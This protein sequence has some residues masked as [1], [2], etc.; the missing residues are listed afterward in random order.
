M[1]I[2]KNQINILLIFLLIPGYYTLINP[3]QIV[4]ITVLSYI[5][6]LFMCV[7]YLF[8]NNSYNDHVFN[9]FIFAGFIIV[10][11]GF[12]NAQTK[13]DYGSLLLE[14]VPVALIVPF[15]YIIGKNILLTRFVL[16]KIFK[17]SFAFLI[18]PLFVYVFI[19]KN[20]DTSI[21][22]RTISPFYFLIL[23]ILQVNPYNKFKIG[24]ISVISIIVALDHRSNIINILISFIIL[25]F[26]SYLPIIV[27]YF[28][29]KVWL[30][31]SF[32]PLIFLYL[33]F[34]NG[35]FDFTNDLITDS[36]SSIYN[37]VYSAIANEKAFVFGLGPK[38]VE[39]SLVN[40]TH[41]NTNDIYDSGRNASESLMLNYFHWGGVVMMLLFSYFVLKGVYLSLF[42]SRNKI[43]LMIALLVLFR[44]L[45][46]FVE[47]RLGYD[48]SSFFYFLL[49]GLA[50]NQ[51]LRNM[52][53]FQVN[54]LF[55]I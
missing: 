33:N 51:Q 2:T 7:K 14:I 47:Y 27:K 45:Y 40:S 18:I 17:Y 46:S 34:Y 23:I 12:I 13:S 49:I 39:T 37:D 54:K 30:L 53:D 4:I 43:S 9:A 19:N 6:V 35:S 55:K 52:N 5:L 11:R 24:I 25:I 3:G 42:K 26:V 20:L 38:K 31:L 22:I 32:I 28:G 48:M 1:K 41:F 44:Y 16:I 8:K 50:Y 21:F 10:F 29:K 15:F 36:R